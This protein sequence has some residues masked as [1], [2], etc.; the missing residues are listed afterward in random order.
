M[1]SSKDTIAEII[2]KSPESIG[3]FRKLG[4]DYCCGA[5]ATLDVAARKAGVELDVVEQEFERATAADSFLPPR[6]HSWE[7]GFLAEFIEQ[8][9]HGYERLTIPTVVTLLDKVISKHGERF[10]ELQAIRI[11]FADMADAL[12]Q[13][14]DDE[15]KTVFVVARTQYGGQSDDVRAMCDRHEADH[16]TISRK[17]DRLRT[18]TNDFTAPASACT[19]HKHTYAILAEF[20]D[21]LRQHVY[22]ENA[23]LFPALRNNVSQTP[24]PRYGVL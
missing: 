14:F 2:R 4:I 11:V 1:L 8:N 17:I 24:F 9:H 15:E 21:D 3:I 23:V 22:L 18:L 16:L 12:L 19:T 10:P 6:V 20:I 13:H 5:G 7:P